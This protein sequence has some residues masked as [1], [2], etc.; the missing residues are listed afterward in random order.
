MKSSSVHMRD[1]EKILVA[2]LEDA[3][4]R[5]GL[6][7]TMLTYEFYPFWDA[8]FSEMGIELVLSDKTNR[9]I[10]NDG[11]GFVVAETCFPIKVMLG[12]I[13][14]LLDKEVD[15]IFIPSIRD[16]PCDNKKIE[17]ERTGS[18][19]C[20]FVQ[21]MSTFVKASLPVD[22]DKILDPLINFSFKEF[23]KNDQLL[24]LG[25][26]LGKNKK[27]INSAV[28]AAYKAQENFY[29][30][31][32][33]AGE[34]VIENL[35]EDEFAAV[36]ISRPYNSCDASISMDIPGKLRDLGIQAIP[37][38]YL[39]VDNVD[40]F[41]Q[42][43]NMYWE[44]GDR[45]LSAVDIIKKDKRLFPV[46][47]TNFG[48]GPDSFIMQFFERE[49]D[50][51]FL[52][53]EVD[54]HTAGA[55]V[56][57][58]CEA[59]YDS[60]ANIKKLKNGYSFKEKKISIPDPQFKRKDN[61]ILY[62]PYMG[63]GAYAIQAAFQS[64][65]IDAEIM[66]SD[67]ETL[68]IGRKHTLGKECYPYILT[69]GD[70]LKTLK[71]ND[72]SKCAF[73]MPLTHGPCRFGQYNQ[74]QK[75]LLKELG[76]HDV[77]IISP[78]APEGQQFYKE[79]DMR[80]R[81]G[82][83]LFLKAMAGTFAVDYLTKYLHS[84][85]PY[86]INK[87]QTEEVYNGLVDMVCEKL[88]DPGNEKVIASMA[89]II[90]LAEKR[91]SN[92]AANRI[93]KPL[94]GIVGEIYVRNHPFSNNEIIK[95]VEQL[96]GEVQIPD[97]GEWAY[98]TN[99]TSKLDNSIKQRDLYFKTLHNIRYAFSSNGNGSNSNGSNGNGSNISNFSKGMKF[100][101]ANRFL[102][103]ILHRYHRLLEHDVK[104]T[105]LIDLEETDIYEIWDNAEP[106]IIKWFGEA[107][108]SVGKSIHWINKGADGIIN[109][110]PFT[111]MPGTMVTAISKRIREEYKV[112]W[113]NLAFDG[114][115]QGTTDT[116]LEAFLYQAKQHK[117][118]KQYKK[119]KLEKVL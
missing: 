5:I 84:T 44:F 27:L 69:T 63:D 36:I 40:L 88:K 113:L 7:F 61:R 83:S 117:E 105:E 119:D 100:H 96:G 99:A 91:F 55:G 102:N 1:P 94:I 22:F 2:A 38:D 80:G 21:G 12:H 71:Y 104:D 68:E 25:K 34:K 58:R 70:I 57:T 97:I 26:K 15:Y 98:H 109:V 86:E 110:L 37:L 77:P 41:N 90:S 8:F 46:Y 47:I 48:C 51:P 112:P 43:P 16:M 78:G 13:Q 85:R 92:I 67:Y 108:L 75:I 50:R 33:S 24:K 54:E 28:K 23:L 10:I 56:I 52:K 59:F 3:H 115:E 73:L 9:K 87:G 18:Y 20:P 29:R 95:K 60:L 39:S 116:R 66:M 49:I 31:L 65:G 111:C 19:P 53:I 45:I 64:G 106:Y 14:N 62:I 35:R 81:K 76:Y 4:L 89:G 101:I 103:R 93:R 72:P 79:Y 32:K 42:W 118:E 17:G 74:M 6:P 82:S 107:A 11:L 114:L 30:D